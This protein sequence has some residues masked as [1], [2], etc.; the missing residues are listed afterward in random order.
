MEAVT[1]K[2]RF[3][4]NVQKLRVAAHLTQ[5][6]LADL[7]SIDRSFL[8]RIEAGASSPSTEVLL[9]LKRALNCTWEQIFDGLD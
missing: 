4:Q 7:A 3:G 9:R 8:Q 1:V 5:N 2:R 6:Q